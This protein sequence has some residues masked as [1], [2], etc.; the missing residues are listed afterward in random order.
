MNVVVIDL[1]TRQPRAVTGMTSQDVS[2]FLWGNNERILFFMD[3]DGS[4]SFGIFAVNTDGS[5]QHSCRGFYTPLTLVMRRTPLGRLFPNSPVIRRHLLLDYDHETPRAVDWVIGACMVLL[6]VVVIF[7]PHGVM[8]V[9]DP[10]AR[11]GV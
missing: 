2:G 9:L 11:A 5:L 3:K 1:A 7:F 4:E 8:G 10:R 6:A